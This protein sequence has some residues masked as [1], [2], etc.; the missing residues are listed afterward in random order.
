MAFTLKQHLLLGC[1]AFWCESQAAANEFALEEDTVIDIATQPSQAWQT[2]SDQALGDWYMKR[3]YWSR[4]R[5]NTGNFLID[6]R[7]NP[8]F[9]AK[10]HD[11]SMAYA[12][13]AVKLVPNL[14]TIALASLRYFK[15]WQ[16]GKVKF[17]PN[18]DAPV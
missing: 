11:R 2:L 16:T 3:M 17:A 14:Q 4:K 7:H 9:W 15:D 18:W 12:V 1:Q 13:Q 6:H 10:Q 8:E 5:A